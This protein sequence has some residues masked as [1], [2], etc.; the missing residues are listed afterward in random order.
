MLFYNNLKSQIYQVQTFEDKSQLDF[1]EYT[2]DFQE[3]LLK[4]KE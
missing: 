3:H 1:L 2:Q 4:M